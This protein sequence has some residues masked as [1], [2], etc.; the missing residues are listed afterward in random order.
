M[1][2]PGVKHIFQCKC[3]YPRGW[4]DSV[5]I[6]AMGV[7]VW[8]LMPA[9]PGAWIRKQQAALLHAHRKQAKTTTWQNSGSRVLQ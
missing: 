7:A 1:L 2:H 3:P 6:G 9:T 4:E 5:K 8:L